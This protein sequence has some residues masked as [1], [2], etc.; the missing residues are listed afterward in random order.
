MHKIT[1]IL[2]EFVLFSLIFQLN[3]ANKTHKIRHTCETVACLWEEF[4]NKLEI[5]VRHHIICSINL[6]EL[7]VRAHRNHQRVY[8]EKQG[9]IGG[10]GPANLNFNAA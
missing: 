6:E 3:D 7:V 2:F 1:L 5:Y 4:N 8:T 9:N 10:R